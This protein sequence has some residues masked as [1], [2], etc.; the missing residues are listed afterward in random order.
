M[1]LEPWLA[2]RSVAFSCRLRKIGDMV[3]FFKRSSGKS[4]K[5]ARKETY[6]YAQDFCASRTDVEAYFEAETPREPAS[7]MLV[8][9]DGEWTRRRSPKSSDA[10]KLQRR[11]PGFHYMRLRVP[12]IH[13]LS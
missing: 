11:T 6:E 9:H 1:L 10:A 8:A 4:A 7:I 2:S 13:G 12:D 5:V 3:W